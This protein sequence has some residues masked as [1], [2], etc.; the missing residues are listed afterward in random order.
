MLSLMVS[1]KAS[2]IA[3]GSTAA[4]DA[5]VRLGQT[6][7]EVGQAGLGQRRESA[8]RIAFEVDAVFQ[9][10]GAVLDAV[11]N[12]ISTSSAGGAA[13]AATGRYPV[14]SARTIQPQAEHA[15]G[16]GD[17]LDGLLAQILEV[18]R[19]SY[20]GYGRARRARCRCRR[21]RPALRDGRRC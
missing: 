6:L 17:V 11:P 14:R 12:A 19:R 20:G 4:I 18:R 16:L 10:A 13:L 1:Q 3:L 21:A 7:F 9:R 8:V 15:D 2:S 5:S